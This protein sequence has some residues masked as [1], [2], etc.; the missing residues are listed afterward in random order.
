MNVPD[1]NSVTGLQSG[2]FGC[3]RWLLGLSFSLLFGLV[4]PGQAAVAANPGGLPLLKSITGVHALTDAEADQAY[5]VDIQG[6]VVSSARFKNLLFLMS[7]G[8]GVVVY[9]PG[10]NVNVETGSEVGVKGFTVFQDGLQIVARDVV[11]LNPDAGVPEPTKVRLG[12]LSRKR[13]QLQWI[14]VAGTIKSVW[15]NTGNS[16][17][18]GILRQGGHTLELRVRPPLQAAAGQLR[19][20]TVRVQGVL[21]DFRQMGIDQPGQVLWVGSRTNVFL[22][23]V[24]PKH[25]FDRETHP[26]RKLA[27]IKP[28]GLWA[29]RPRVSGTV[30]GVVD[31]GSGFEVKD[32]TGVMRV[33]PAR[34]GMWRMG[35][36][37]EVVG[38]TE[39][40]EAGIFLGSAEVQVR[41][42]P[43]SRPQGDLPAPVPVVSTVVDLRTLERAAVATRPPVRLE[44]TITYNDSGAKLC[45]L[46]QG[47]S[48]VQLAATPALDNLPV[49]A[50]VLIDGYAQMGEFAPLV[51]PERVSVVRTNTLPVPITGQH[52]ALQS[53]RLDGSW[54]IGEGI[55]RSARTEA[56]HLVLRLNRFGPIFPVHVLGGEDLDP[57]AYVDSRVTVTGVAQAVVN[58][59]GLVVD[60]RILVPGRRFLRIV[61]P[62]PENPF[63]SLSVR[64]V[65]KFMD[66]TAKGTH[67][68]RLRIEGV[69]TLSWPGK[70]YVEDDTG[71]IEVLTSEEYNLRMG[72]R[73]SVIGFPVLGAQRPV[74]EDAEIR[75]IGEGEI[76]E[77]KDT[78]AHWA[79]VN[80]L[81]GHRAVFTGQLLSKTK[82]VREYVLML[83]D[84]DVAVPMILR[85]RIGP[86]ELENLEIGSDLRAIGICELSESP[87]RKLRDVRLLVDSARDIEVTG[88]PPFWNAGRMLAAVSG[89]ALIIAG[90]LGWVAFLSKRVAQTQNRFATAFRASPVPVAIMTRSERRILDVNDSF[91][92]KFEFSRR[93]VVARLFDDLQICL[94]G[95]LLDRVEKQLAANHSVRAVDCELRSASGKARYVLLSVETIDV[96]DE[97]CLLFIFQDVTERLALMDQLRESQKMEA[98][99][100]LAAGVAH[101]FNN[102][103]TIIRGNTD[104]LA[105]IGKGDD[106]LLEISGELSEATT[107][108]SDLTRQLL[109][110]SRKQ[111]MQPRIVDLNTVIAGG[112]KMVKRL[113]GENISVASNLAHIELPVFADAGMLDQ[114]LINLVVNARDAM[115]GEGTV[116]IDTQVE[117]L[118]DD[119]V[120][121]HADGRTGTHAVFR[122]TDTG[123]GMDLETRKRIF[124][125]FYTTKEV[126]KGTGLGLATVYG[127]AKQHR[128][129][130]DV[131]SEV[132]A[133]SSF[134]IYLPLAESE[135]HQDTVV[136]AT[137]DNLKG[138][139][140]ILVAEDET[141]VRRMICRT[142]ERVGYSIWEAD[143][144]EGAKELWD[145]HKSDIDLLLTDLMMPGGKS[146]FDLAEEL[147]AERE[148]LP[149]IFVSGYSAEMMERGHELDVG[150]NFL[151]K[152]FTNK[153]LLEIVRK[154][155]DLRTRPT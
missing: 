144:A 100:Q 14:E 146:G 152:P 124:E 9:A 126:G 65:G 62:P 60:C 115:N 27:A 2:L 141:A 147:A 145:A 75:R 93:K 138:N 117:E 153:S 13:E 11:V 95:E 59:Q 120:K 127:I 86:T 24:Y 57:A 98:V 54:I 91:V 78:H 19:F 111:V 102:L 32:T 99:G 148:D 122:V 63:E 113:V 55:V 38:Y 121:N 74:L 133:G 130:I 71:S 137:I 51:D 3:S 82:G 29:F 34:R 53:G 119:D 79:L 92:E 69:V 26:I 21:M 81:N 140:G 96:D 123:A 41:A 36:L 23:K 125:P 83:K 1:A 105:D 58:R 15:A 85:K 155:M 49:G 7:A 88:R 4:T 116:T 109:A 10:T 67:L 114:I 142:L 8:K 46:Q 37:V 136:V 40:D 6:I 28:G 31:D 139:E 104:I 47:E 135:D 44:G 35:D 132:G 48:G 68:R 12:G 16:R 73:V 94:D 56:N 22:E 101:D 103:L 66:Y 143:D 149:V 45:F 39:T 84:G 61:S 150:V 90:S 76:P 129:W 42:T 20:S 70:V 97:E 80:D 43:K 128:G 18:T 72:D 5:P 107:R 131:S 52:G 50:Q 108:A 154:R 17:M 118:D 64:K 25:P 110:F 89:M 106:E 33:V 134:C 151:S 112:L 77:A 87:G 30:V